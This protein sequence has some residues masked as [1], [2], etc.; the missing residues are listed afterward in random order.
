MSVST[1]SIV[2]KELRALADKE[3]AK[4][5]TWFFKTGKGEYG[6]GDVFLGIEVPAIRE[7]AKRHQELDLDQI[8][9]LASSKYHEERFIALAIMVLQFKKSKQPST[10]EKLFDTYLELLKANRV[11]NWDLV[12]ASAPYLGVYLLDY[13]G[14]QALLA[15]LAKSKNLWE[16]R[17]SIMFTWAYIRAGQPSVT[18]KQ[19]EL[20]LD[21]PHDLIHK[22]SGWML[23]EVGKKD[24]KQ[25][26][27]FLASHA[28]TMPRVMLRYSIEKMTANE[29]A[30]WLA[31]AKG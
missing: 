30:K 8:T 27:G 3:T 29:R 1:A 4:S 22:A 24:L 10:R 6:Y 9:K 23:R 28:A 14:A 11:N 25:L 18:T 12:D 17:A 7:V 21:H 15:K 31:K 2:S 16:Q 5:R 20:F 19:V 13:P 26:K